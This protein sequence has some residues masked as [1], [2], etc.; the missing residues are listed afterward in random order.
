MC[1][2]LITSS[3]QAVQGKRLGLKFVEEYSEVEV[4]TGVRFQLAARAV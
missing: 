3:Y 4:E 2:S 1:L